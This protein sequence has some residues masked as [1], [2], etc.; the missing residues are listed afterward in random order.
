[1]NGQFQPAQ[2][3]EAVP[4]A[5]GEPRQWIAK[6][7]I[8]SSARKK[9]GRG[10]EEGERRKQLVKSTAPPP[11]GEDAEHRAEDEAQDRRRADQDQGPGERLVQD[12]ATDNGK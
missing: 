3:R 4:L 9:Y 8:S 11:A 6:S 7:S 12:V 2:R 5:G 1:M 10:L